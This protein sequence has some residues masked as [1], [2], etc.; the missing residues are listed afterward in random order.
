[1]AKKK[2]YSSS[3][4][5]VGP[6]LPPIIGQGEYSKS[7][8]GVKYFA[9]CLDYYG[10]LIRCEIRRKEYSGPESEMELTGDAIKLS[11]TNKDIHE[12]I[13]GMGVKISVWCNTDGQY[14]DL[15]ATSDKE[16]MVV[17]YRAGAVIF[18]G[19]IDPELYT[20]DFIAPPYSI[21]IPAT[22]GL[23]ALDSYYPNLDFSQ[24]RVTL[25][26]ILKLSLQQT[27]LNLPILINC[28]L[29]PET[30]KSGTMFDYVMID[31]MALVQNAN[32]YIEKINAKETI[33]NLL[34]GFSCRI[35]QSNGRWYIDRIKNKCDDSWH[36][37]LYDLDGTKSVVK[38]FETVIID[39]NDVAYVN[40]PASLEIDSGYGKQTIDINYEK[41]D[42]IILNNA[43]VSFDYFNRENDMFFSELKRWKY[44]HSNPTFLSAENN[45]NGI[46]KAI[47]Q[48]NRTSAVPEDSWLQ[49]FQKSRISHDQNAKLHIAFKVACLGSRLDPNPPDLCLPILVGLKPLE[50]NPDDV[51]WYL[52]QDR[53]G[54]YV[55]EEK[56]ETTIQHT[57]SKDTWKNAGPLGHMSVSFDLEFPEYLKNGAIRKM[58]YQDEIIL[59]VGMVRSLGWGEYS[60]IGDFE[61]N[62]ANDEVDNIFEAIVNTKYRR[63]APDIEMKFYD[64]PR[65]T[66]L[67]NGGIVYEGSNLNYNYGLSTGTG[68]NDFT[69]QWFDYVENQDKSNK[70]YERLFID[71][72]D[73]YYDPR[74]KLSGEILTNQYLAPEKLY[75]VTGRNGKSYMLTGL[76]YSPATGVY[77]L[78]IEE[79]KTRQVEIGQ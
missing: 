8:G 31:S 17:I 51:I 61:V 11:R 23:A 22:D 53:D 50:N 41:F 73:Q 27:G 62:T 34:R 74:E 19:F 44:L 9:E 56:K 1:M 79:I 54:N 25:L 7:F 43:D 32:G 2:T 29:F 71:N 65:F 48:M 28:S 3:V 39:T 64:I 67:N 5:I 37:V 45:K 69:Y 36:W 38:N 30:G 10:N 18:R 15:F 63:P 77:S 52:K 13:C 40:N 68:I 60:I 66:I 14:L 70:L 16:H 49:Y 46:S 59:A 35:Y 55:W 20:E 33:T 57:I 76:D 78:Q 21:T 6:T 12:Q 75:R 26:E 58:S 4:S 72:F 42:T 47:V 24:D